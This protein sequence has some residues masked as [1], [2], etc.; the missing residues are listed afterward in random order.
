MTPFGQR[1]DSERNR[2]LFPAPRGETGFSLI[3]LLITLALILIM[4][5]MLFSPSARSHQRKQK[6]ACQGN[7]QNIYVA[8]QIYASDHDGAFPARG[9]AATAEAALAQLVP[10]YTS[11]TAPF[12]C[13]GSKDR[14]LPE[15]ESFEQRKIS[16]AY[17]MGRRLADG[18]AALMTDEQVNTQPKPQ[19]QPVFSTDGK[20]PGRNH[21][22]YGGNFLFSDGHLA[23]SGPEAPFPLLLPEGVALLNP[24]P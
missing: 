23:M 8:L 1:F 10:R 12:I 9:D 13:P 11:V 2:S 24:K 4:Y 5:V 22:K 6:L 15:G 14:T 17:Y 3:E 21:H 16:Y 20:G 18:R 7:L 19:G